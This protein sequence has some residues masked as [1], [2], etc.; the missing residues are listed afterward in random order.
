MK[1]AMI[2]DYLDNEAYLAAEY[3]N[4]VPATAKQIDFLASLFRKKGIDVKS[5]V[6]MNTGLA[7]RHA[8]RLITQL[9][10]ESDLTFAEIQERDREEDASD[11][12]AAVRQNLR[13]SAK[14]TEK[15]ENW[16]NF[17]DSP[18]SAIKVGTPISCT[19]ESVGYG[20]KT[21]KEFEGTIDRREPRKAKVRIVGKV[22]EK[23]GD[24]RETRT[25]IEVGR[26]SNIRIEQ[27]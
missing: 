14:A 21:Y 6:P 26:L 7:T 9:Q 20:P 2:I 25:N 8:S 23:N 12:Q 3:S 27:A 4:V 24:W 10:K 5:A 17:K 18:I 19:I 15:A 11:R 16:D 1:K 22:L 13:A